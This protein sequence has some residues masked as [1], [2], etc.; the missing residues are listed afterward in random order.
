MLVINIIAALIFAGLIGARAQRTVPATFYVDSERGDDSAEGLAPEA[1]WRSLDRVNS[2][3]LVPGDKVLFKRGGLWRGT[4]RAQKGAK[5]AP[6][7]YGAYG[8]GPKPII[9]GSVARDL[10]DQWIEESPGIWATAPLVPKRHNQIM[11]LTDSMWNASFQEKAKGTVRRAKED[12]VWFNRVT[13]AESSA[14]RNLILLWG[15]QIRETGKWLLLRMRVRC[16]RPFKMEGAEIMLNR[17]PWTIAM[18]GK[19]G[20]TLIGPEWQTIEIYLYAKEKAEPAHLHLY[21]GG[22][23]PSGAIFDFSPLGIWR[24][25]FDFRGP[26]TADVGI[27]ILNHGEK[28]GVKKWRREDLKTPLD[29]WYDTELKRVVVACEENPALKFKSVEL[30]LTRHIVNQGSC[31]DLVYDGLAVR[32]GAAHGFGGGETRRIMIRNCDIYWIG[33]GLQHWKKNKG[34]KQYPVRF[35][36]AIEFWGAAEDHLVESN[37]IWEVYDAAL[38]NQGNGD[39]SHQLNIVYRH[40]VIWN[41]EYSFEFWNRP[42][43]ARTENILFEHNTCVDAGRGWAHAQRPDVNGAHL[44][45]YKSPSATT[46]FVIRNNIFCRSSDRCTRMFNDWR[47]GLTLNNN[48]YWSPDKPVMRWLEKTNYALK[49]FARYQSEL[50]LDQGSLAAEPQFVNP[51]ARDYRLKPGSPGG[52]LATDGGP[53]GARLSRG[54]N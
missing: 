13:C 32:Y 20:S 44:M 22:M 8:A 17:P 7:L 45:F 11:D 16:T 6:L 37:R 47:A 19:A 31:R 10:P 21:L 33:G 23:I 1:P 54:D 26:L 34:G 36:N 35:G 5:E 25:S 27:L 48:L 50:G 46:N 43:V 29:Y 15:P 24:A 2:A 3:E 51:G 41:A 52:T 4:L 49:D 30:A 14:K 38:T 28:W 9:Q 53:A 39:N 18:Q 40:N 42:A 12:G